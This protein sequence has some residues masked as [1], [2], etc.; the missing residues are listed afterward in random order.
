[1]IPLFG[2][3]EGDRGMSVSEDCLEE[4]IM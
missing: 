1:M 4:V 2:M 3:V